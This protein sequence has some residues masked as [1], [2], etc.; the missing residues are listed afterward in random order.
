VSCPLRVP[1]PKPVFEG[2][3]LGAR[4]LYSDQPYKERAL[5]FDPTLAA[6]RFGTG[7]SPSHAPAQS[8]E[9]L[10]AD[11][12]GPDHMARRHPIPGFHDVS[13]SLFEM[14]QANRQRREARG[15]A[16]EDAAEARM[17]ALR[18]AA[19]DI[20]VANHQASVARMLDTAFGLGER[21]TDFWADHFTVKSRNFFEQHLIT[22]YVQD[23]IRPHV[24]GRFP[25]MLRAVVLHP[26]MLLF[27]EQ[28]RS[29]GPQSAL[30]VRTGR[31]LNENLARELLELHLLGVDGGYGQSDVRELAELLTGLTYQPHRGFFYDPRMAE[32]GGERVLGVTFSGAASLDTVLDALD[33]LALHPYTAAHLAHKLAVHFVRPD[34][35]PGMV[36]GSYTHLT[37]PASISGH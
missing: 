33:A 7:L 22:P 8:V 24:A 16:D 18:Q 2:F 29:T 32:P 1:L 37:L 13:P 11:L 3:Q 36:A 17:A 21:L 5:P 19:N 23:A 6:I 28:W 20:R 27:L 15:T 30:G 12:S 14:R 26:M 31:G 34:P 10:L 35:A 9:A 4:P 25:D